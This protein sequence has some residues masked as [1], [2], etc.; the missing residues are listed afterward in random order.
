MPAS[1]RQVAAPPKA[2]K[3][4][5]SGHIACDNCFYSHSR[6]TE[7]RPCAR[8]DSK[9]IECATSR[10]PPPISDTRSRVGA[11]KNLN[12]PYEIPAQHVQPSMWLFDDLDPL[13][14]DTVM[15]QLADRYIQLG[16]VLGVWVVDGLVRQWGL[17]SAYRNQP[18][19]FTMMTLAVHFDSTL[20]PHPLM[21]GE[22]SRSMFQMFERSRRTSAYLLNHPTMEGFVS[23]FNL[24]VV[25][26]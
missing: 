11:L 26:E 7:T 13:P 12:R 15:F 16:R 8:C 9:G 18:L 3:A 24:A 5:D 22:L 6:C 21:K 14:P 10:L 1:K 17:S 25:S 20:L 19:Y 23:L 4:M 2:K